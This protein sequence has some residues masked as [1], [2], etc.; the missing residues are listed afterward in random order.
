MRAIPAYF[1]NLLLLIASTQV[2]DFVAFENV[3]V[4]VFFSGLFYWTIYN[5][6]I[7]PLWFVFLSG[8]VIDF[9]VDSVLGLHAFTF[10]I[11]TMILYRGRRV[12]I[13]QPMLYHIMIYA[14]SAIAFEVIRWMLLGILTWQIMPIF[15]SMISIILNIIFFFPILLVLKAVHRVMSG[16]GKRR[17]F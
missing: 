9:S 5:P 17:H 2:I 11:Y 16:Y 10:I 8:L 6:S 3:H 7:M 14:L 1:F 12:I 15:P 13:S 4:I